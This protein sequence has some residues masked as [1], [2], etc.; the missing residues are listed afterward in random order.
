V[1]FVANNAIFRVDKKRQNVI[2]FTSNKERDSLPYGMVES[3]SIT[4]KENKNGQIIL[5]CRFI[6]HDVH[7]LGCF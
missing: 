3:P 4:K 1:R 5:E 2:S 6:M 7:I